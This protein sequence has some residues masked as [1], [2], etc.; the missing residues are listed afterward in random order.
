M[1]AVALDLVVEGVVDGDLIFPVGVDGVGEELEARAVS[2]A[3]VAARVR[4]RGGEEEVGVDGFVQEGV[5]GVGA[6]AVL[7]QRRA[8]FE[9]DAGQL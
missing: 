4:P 1:R 9:A 5:D 7:Q 3:V 8:E 6:R 2:G